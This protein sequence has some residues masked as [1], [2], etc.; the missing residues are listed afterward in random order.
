MS[1][2]DVSAAQLSFGL[3]ALRFGA[4]GCSP[5]CGAGSG[6][7]SLHPGGLGLL[8]PRSSNLGSLLSPLVGRHIT[9]PPCASVKPSQKYVSEK[10]RRFFEREMGRERSTPDSH[11][12]SPRSGGEG[13]LSPALSPQKGEGDPWGPRCGM[14][15]HPSS[16]ALPSTQPLRPL[17]P[18]FPPDAPSLLLCCLSQPL[19]SRAARHVEITPR[20]PSGGEGPAGPI[21]LHARPPQ[22]INRRIAQDHLPGP[23][24]A[25][26]WSP[27]WRHPA[28]M[29]P[30]L[31]R[32]RLTLSKPCSSGDRNLPN[33]P[34]NARS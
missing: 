3:G 24:A 27:I 9:R 13:A 4:T 2:L 16:K 11:P 23:A 7:K 33:T 10:N 28:T 29:R 20:D 5:P 12:R 32:P 15:P 31:A 34:K 30:R 22:P 19:P 21:L 6:P 1:N 18:S 17:Q 8:Q 26:I 25:D 14:S